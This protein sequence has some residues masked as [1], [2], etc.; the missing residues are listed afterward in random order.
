MSIIKAQAITQE[1]GLDML[2]AGLSVYLLC[3]VVSGTTA[4]CTAVCLWLLLKDDKNH[5]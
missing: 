2:D 4:L 1:R 3:A 5:G